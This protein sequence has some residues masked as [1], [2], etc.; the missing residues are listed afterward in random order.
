MPAN[1]L[2]LL[3]DRLE[4]K[5]HQTLAFA[6]AAS[7]SASS[8]RA[9]SLNTISSQPSFYD[10]PSPPTSL[11][12]VIPR[13]RTGSPA[14]STRPKHVQRNSVHSSHS[15]QS[16]S[17]VKSNRLGIVHDA[18]VLSRLIL[19]VEVGNH[20]SPGVDWAGITLDVSR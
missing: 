10:S 13:S 15:V 9:T 18:E 14:Y 6:G 1:K 12:S 8:S 2:R 16:V 3:I 4:L 17:S 11:R 20:F 5:V 7:T 19:G